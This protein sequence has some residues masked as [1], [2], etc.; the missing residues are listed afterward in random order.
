MS[1][2]GKLVQLKIII[3]SEFG[4]SQKENYY[5]FSLI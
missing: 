3:L 5:R 4:Q 2:V 1:F